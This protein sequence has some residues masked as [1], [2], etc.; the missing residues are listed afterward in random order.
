MEGELASPA[1]PLC[2][3]HPQA[4]PHS[5]SPM[6]AKS[7]S[8]HLLRISETETTRNLLQEEPKSRKQPSLPAEPREMGLSLPTTK[9][10]MMP[11]ADPL[12]YA[13]SA[14]GV[15]AGNSN[16]SLRGTDPEALPS[17]SKAFP[18]RDQNLSA[19]TAQPWP[20]SPFPP[21]QCSCMQILGTST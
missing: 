9:C 21:N 18:F 7:P 20:P 11:W 17:L 6:H 5:C 2:S 3:P 14:H 13:V 8:K 10:S 16:P 4:L 19:R 12:S 15:L 1:R